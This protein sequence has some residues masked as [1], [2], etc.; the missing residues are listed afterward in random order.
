MRKAIGELKRVAHRTTRLRSSA[1]PSSQPWSRDNAS[2][3][4][5]GVSRI[6]E[7]LH[8]LRGPADTLLT[9][10]ISHLSDLWRLLPKSDGIR[11]GKL[12][13]WV[14]LGGAYGC[15][16]QTG[17]HHSTKERTL[18]LDHLPEIYARVEMAGRQEILYP[19]LRCR[20]GQR[21][22]D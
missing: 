20:I 16:N 14:L 10:P 6:S 2:S 19:V 4:V 21:K 1:S 15:W 18:L 22:L 8:R 7:A 17:S 5:V 13:K 11:S 12:I 9:I 3:S